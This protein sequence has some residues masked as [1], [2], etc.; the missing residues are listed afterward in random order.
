[1]V[2]WCLCKR[3]GCCGIVFVFL[4]LVKVCFGFGYVI[5]LGFVFIGLKFLEIYGGI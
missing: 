2:I 3:L 5:D 1:M 4:G